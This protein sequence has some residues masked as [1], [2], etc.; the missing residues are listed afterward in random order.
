MPYLCDMAFLFS[1]ETFNKIPIT[2]TQPLSDCAVESLKGFNM[3][4]RR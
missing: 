4:S 2:H 1:A 3:S